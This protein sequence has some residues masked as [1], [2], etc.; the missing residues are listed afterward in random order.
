MT[1]TTRV[2]CYSGPA[3]VHGHDVMVELVAHR[4]PAGGDGLV[5]WDG[6]ALIVDEEDARDLVGQHVILKV[7][8]ADAEVVACG[9]YQLLEGI[10]E[11]RLVGV[12]EPPFVYKE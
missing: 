2:G 10:H 11:V 6:F 7:A 1:T 8:G 9:D 4:D 12:G 3:L 5:T